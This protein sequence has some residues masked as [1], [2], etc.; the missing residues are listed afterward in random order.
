[1][2]IYVA[3][4]PIFKK[5]K[6]I[7]GY[8]L[9]FRG[10]MDNYF[11]DNI[12]GDTATSKLLS[13]SFLTMGIEK[14]TGENLAFVNFTQDLLVNRVPLLFPR[15]KMVVEVLE[16][17]KPDADVIKVCEEFKN[18]GY[19]IALDDFFYT[20]SLDE[21]VSHA[22][23]IKFDLRATPFD[24]IEEWIQKLPKNGPDLL[25]EKV[26]TYDEFQQAVDMGFRYFQGY[27]FSKPEVIRGKD[28]SSSPMLML[29]IMAE[30]NKKDF[31]FEKLENI[32]SKD[33]SITYKLFRTINSTYYSTVNKV[34]SV[35]QAIV[36]LGEK[37]IRRFVSLLAMAKLAVGKPDELVRTSIVRARFCEV[38]GEKNGSRES[39]SELFVLGL[40]SLIDAIL[41]DNMHKLL[42]KL[43]LSGAI[44]TALTKGEGAFSDYLKLAVSYET[45]DWQG[46]SRGA[47]TLGLKEE[48]LPQYYMDALEWA[49]SI[50]KV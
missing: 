18:K 23:I 33:V 28:I 36:M 45:G 1:M 34:T 17:V 12:D 31:K 35:R 10:G 32:I 47:S 40:F 30:A 49:D 2:D 5:N 24:Q 44:K 29:Q 22:N 3:R 43:P 15:E 20:S 4:Q 7:Y 41:D 27:F 16:D 13:D 42:E 8:E 48:A 38:I 37:G 50:T 9:L 6:T 46:V 25:A 21:L 39:P 11:P 19:G 26:E 14:I